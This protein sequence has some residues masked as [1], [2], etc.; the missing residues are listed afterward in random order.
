MQTNDLG[1]P[2]DWLGW[3][4]RSFA[5]DLRSGYNLPPGGNPDNHVCEPAVPNMAAMHPWSLT[6]NQYLKKYMLSGGTWPAPD[7]TPQVH[8]LLSDD[9][10]NW[11]AP[12][13]LMNGP[14]GRLRGGSLPGFGGLPES[15]QDTTTRPRT[16]C[17]AT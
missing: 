17:P 2:E 16:G 13:L 7:Q 3:N 1:K 6:Y 15:D 11:S 9:L 12:Q 8:Y 14:V 5:V 10:R 4:G